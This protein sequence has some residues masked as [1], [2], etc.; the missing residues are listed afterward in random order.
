MYYYNCFYA[1]VGSAGVGRTGTYIA[2]DILTKEGEAEGAIDIPG[3][4]LNM[5][6]NRPNMVQTEVCNKHALK[7]CIDV[8]CR[9][10][11]GY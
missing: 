4:V 1:D 10:M 11:H 2:I 7:V 5:R 3:C 6:Q 9:L 8:K